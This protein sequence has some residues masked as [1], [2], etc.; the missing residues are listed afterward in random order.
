MYVD[1]SVQG[2]YVNQSEVIPDSSAD[3]AP[4]DLFRRILGSRSKFIVALGSVLV[5]VVVLVGVVRYQPIGTSTSTMGVS[6]NVVSTPNGSQVAKKL[7]DVEG[8]WIMPSGDA[9]L[10]IVATI[11]NRGPMGVEISN[12]GAPVP[13]YFAPL[14]HM[15]RLKVRVGQSS[16]WK[17]D[18]GFKPFVL[19]SH[20]SERVVVR[21]TFSCD[22]APGNTWD[23]STLPIS[24]SFL[25]L[26]HHV[27][28]PI[29]PFALA[30]P[31]SC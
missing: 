27:A 3:A 22:R 4:R 31:S 9:V 10:E 6:A 30:R 17:R 12:V 21:E 1:R 23:I 24:M 2:P 29:E 20:S 15:S 14:N 8:T 19:G 5:I 18:R 16:S 11:S 7:G 25:G 26:T 13:V 28:V